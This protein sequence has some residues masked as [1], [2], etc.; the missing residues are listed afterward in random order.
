[1]TYPKIVVDS[2]LQT[3]DPKRVHI[4]DREIII[5]YLYKIKNRT[6][7]I[8]TTK[9]MCNNFLSSPNEKYMCDNIKKIYLAKLMNLFEYIRIT[10]SLIPEDFNASYKLSNKE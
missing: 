2:C 4:T 9:C 8:I 5:D 1:M 10:M 6:A 3:C 7:D